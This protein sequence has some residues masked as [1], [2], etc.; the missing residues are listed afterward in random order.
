MKDKEGRGR[1]V[2]K[3]PNIKYLPLKT[4]FNP[5]TLSYEPVIKTKSNENVSKRAKRRIIILS[6][7]L[8]LIAISFLIYTLI[9]IN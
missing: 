9:K 2:V 8:M 6:I 5:G 7:I 4:S 3:R 1:K